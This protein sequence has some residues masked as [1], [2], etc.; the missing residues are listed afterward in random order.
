MILK[1]DYQVDCFV[2]SFFLKENPEIN[3]KNIFLREFESF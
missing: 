1:K 3:F 2:L